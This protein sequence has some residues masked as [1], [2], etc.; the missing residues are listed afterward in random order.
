MHYQHDIFV[1]TQ[2]MDK[3]FYVSFELSVC[4]WC[5]RCSDEQNGE[6]LLLL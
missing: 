4:F 5:L 2:A 6:Q 3:L 1:E